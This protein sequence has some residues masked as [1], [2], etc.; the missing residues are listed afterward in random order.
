MS[1]GFDGNDDNYESPG[2]EENMYPTN[3]WVKFTLDLPMTENTIGKTWNYFTAG[4]VVSGDILDK[5]V[6]GGLKSY[7]DQKL[8]QPLGITDYQ[9]Q[10]TPQKKPSLA[11]GLRMK[12]LDFARFGQLYKNNGVW[13]GKTIL[14]KVWIK[15][16]FTNYFADHKDFEGYGYLF[17]RKVYKAGNR[18]F[19]AYQCSG[20]GG[21]KI[22][23]F[24]E[25]PVVIVITA[26]AY[27]QP[28]AHSQADKIVQE[29]LL[30]A[31]KMGNE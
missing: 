30:P 21:N 14:D 2:N 12:V 19:E 15:K 25:I 6:P 27:N 29:Y 22:I 11:G 9:W 10:L 3:N 20:N 24:T 4:V 5:A 16:S 13:N 7:A 23:V 28:Y 1:S 18:N 26:T 31:L 8:F 17:W